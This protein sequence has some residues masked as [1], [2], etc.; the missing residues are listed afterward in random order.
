M[1]KQT[2]STPE[3]KRDKVFIIK[4]EEALKKRREN[5][6]KFYQSI[7]E[8]EEEETRS[9]RISN[10]KNNCKLWKFCGDIPQRKTWY[11]SQASEVD[12]T[13]GCEFWCWEEDHDIDEDWYAQGPE[14]F[15]K[16]KLLLNPRASERE[17]GRVFFNTVIKYIPKDQVFPSSLK[18]EIKGYYKVGEEKV[19]GKFKRKPRSD[20][21]YPP[22]TGITTYGSGTFQFAHTGTGILKILNF[23]GQRYHYFKQRVQTIERSILTQHQ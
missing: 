2:P 3:Q 17:Y 23:E 9:N 1:L 11:R 8:T 16:T 6:D 13:V 14:D 4:A 20:L 21:Y 15:N 10:H 7:R 5:L 18:Q 22:K 19:Y 12:D